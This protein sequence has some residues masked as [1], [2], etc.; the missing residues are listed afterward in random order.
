MFDHVT[1]LVP[2]EAARWTT[3]VEQCRPVL[4]ADGME[5]VQVLLAEHGMSVIQATAITRALL[6][7]GETPL[8][9]AI[10]TVATSE[11]RATRT[12]GT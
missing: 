1:G 8:R 3:M 11:V 2:E 7:W 5:A 12:P 10:D 4:E 9:V 6:G